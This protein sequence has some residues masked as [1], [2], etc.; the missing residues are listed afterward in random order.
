MTQTEKKPKR[1]RIIWYHVLTYSQKHEM[2][3][4]KLGLKPL[5]PNI[6]DIRTLREK[7]YKRLLKFQQKINRI[8]VLLEDYKKLRLKSRRTAILLW[9]KW[10]LLHYKAVRKY[11]LSPLQRKSVSTFNE[12]LLACLSFIKFQLENNFPVH[13]EIIEGYSIEIMH[14]L[15]YLKV[16]LEWTIVKI[17]TDRRHR[18]FIGSDLYHETR[19]NTLEYSW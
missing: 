1:E 5:P 2:L 7:R 13:M 3:G 15:S 17:R 9:Y 14:S 6:E 16:S 18:Y 12:L 8:I 11:L 19:L 10:F 4:E